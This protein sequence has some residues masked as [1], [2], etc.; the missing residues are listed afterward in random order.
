MSDAGRDT[1]NRAEGTSA[2]DVAVAV[3]T[4][5]PARAPS[6]FLAGT[7]RFVIFATQLGLL[8]VV[9]REFHLE[10][11]GF[12]HLFE[13]AVVSCLIHSLLPFRYRLP[14]FVLVS[15]TG[16]WLVLGTVEGLWLIGVGL[17]LVGLCHLPISFALRVAILLIVAALLAVLR[18]GWFPAPWSAAIWPILGSMFMFRLAVYL[19][20]LRSEKVPTNAWRTLSYFFLLPNVV[21]P[22]FPVVDYKTFRRTY[23]DAEPQRIYQSGI[24]WL[25]RGVVHLLVYRLVYYHFVLTPAQVADSFDLVRFLVSNLLLYLRV[26][27]EFHIIVGMLHLFGFN[28]PETHHL[29]LLASSFN[30]FWRRINI[31]WKDFMLKLFYYPTY[32]RLRRLGPTPAMVLTTIVVFAATW[33]LHSFQWFWLRGSFP[34][35][36]QDAFFWGVLGMCVAVNS[37]LESRKGRE[38]RLGSQRSRTW[39]EIAKRGAQTAST[40]AVICLLWSVWTSESLT[41]WMELWSFTTTEGFSGLIWVTGGLAA[42]VGIRAASTRA[43]FLNWAGARIERVR[44]LS[45]TAPAVIAAL[46]VLVVSVQPA[47]QSRLGWPLGNAVRSVSQARLSGRDTALLERGYYEGLLRV[48][49]FNSQLWEIYAQGPTEPENPADAGLVRPTGDFLKEEL[50]PSLQTRFRGHNF[51][52]NRWGIRDRD[53]TATPEPGT[54]RFAL[55]GSSQVQGAGVG[56]DETFENLVEDRLNDGT[57]PRPYRRYEILNFA[58]GGYGP[59]QELVTLERK[60]FPLDPQAVI[61]VAHS[62]DTLRAVGHWVNRLKAGVRSPYVELDRM[63]ESVGVGPDTSDLLIGGRLEPLAL[64]VVAFVY[65]RVVEQCRSKGVIP[66]WVF[67]PRGETAGH[68]DGPGEL[69]RLATD[70]GFLTIDLSRAYD[71]HP[72]K[73]IWV[74]TW[75]RHP[76]AL[77]HRLL[78]DDLYKGLQDLDSAHS[79]RLFTVDEVSNSAKDTRAPS[80]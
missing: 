77:G 31:Y 49:R 1:F 34:L 30:D 70:A 7:G 54:F 45:H 46:L 18:A 35:Q 22:L 59:L 29:Y 65:R 26:S 2:T 43:T 76:N 56:D 63:A 40:F 47:V 24:D 12:L 68:G 44:Q 20:D 67:M 15:F 42:A 71:N 28:L 48:D 80:N 61:L 57:V 21:F 72:P 64:D 66:I 5:S 16:I 27:G 13:L 19:Y 23:Y 39:A 37:L 58:V 9:I 25:L 62:N 33:I 17:V 10:S 73:S 8:A 3:S 51:S 38:R 36:W 52:I 41:E 78:A 14:F 74:A 6:T 69:Q 50:V 53:Y 75:D 32:F 60:S 79:L 11:S 55:L 4:V